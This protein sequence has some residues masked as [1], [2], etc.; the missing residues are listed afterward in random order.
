MARKQTA[1]KTKG[2]NRDLSVSAFNPEF[3]FENMNLR[4]STNEGNTTMSWVNEKGTQKIDDIVIDKKPWDSPENDVDYIEGIPIG[5]AIIDNKLVL[6]TTQRSTTKILPD[7]IYVLQYS[8]AEKTAIKG[9]MLYSGNLNF[10]ANY[11]IKTLVSYESPDIQKVYWVDG[12]NQPRVINIEASNSKLEKW[13][14]TVVGNE[15]PLDTFFDFVPAIKLDE[16]MTVTQDINS[17]GLFAPG[18]IQYCFS[19]INRNGQQTNIVEVSPLYYLTYADRGAS[20]ED[21]VGCSFK[22]DIKNP[23]KTFDYVRLYS[24][25]RTSLDAVPY[26]KLLDDIPVSGTTR[27]ELFSRK[28]VY[29]SNHELTLPKDRYGRILTVTVENGSY[30]VSIEAMAGT[31]SQ[32]YA[33]SSSFKIIGVD[34]DGQAVHTYDIMTLNELIDEVYN[35]SA[36]EDALFYNDYSAGI[37]ITQSVSTMLDDEVTKLQCDRWALQIGDNILYGRDVAQFFES[38]FIY[39]YKDQRWYISIENA[40]ETVT[41]N[42]QVGT[43]ITYVDNGTSGSSMDPQELLFVGGK[44]ITALTISDKDNTLF[45]GNLNEKNP[46]VTKIQDFFNSIRDV[47]D[48]EDHS[49]DDW[50][51]T[52]KSDSTK[53]LKMDVSRGFYHNTF[54]LNGKNHRQIT[55]FKGGETYRFG[56][57][58]Q[59]VTGEWTEPVWMNDAYNDKYPQCSLYK[60]T[61]NLVHAEVNFDFSKLLSELPDVD[62]SIY[63]RIRPVVVYPTIGDR[64]VLCQGVLNP[65][66]FNAMDRIDNSPYAQASWYFRPYMTGAGNTVPDI[67][68]E[69][70]SYVE[71]HETTP[72]VE[73]VDLSVDS[74][75]VSNNLLQDVYVMRVHADNSA[76]ESIRKKGSVTTRFHEEEYDPNRRG[77]EILADNWDEQPVTI[78]NTSTP[79]DYIF[80]S[81]SPFVL[82]YEEGGINEQIESE[83]Y[84]VYFTYPDGLYAM[85]M[86]IADRSF[87]LYNGMDH[88]SMYS[89]YYTN[90]TAN[91]SLDTYTFK[92]VIGNTYYSITFNSAGGAGN[93]GYAPYIGNSSGN[94]VEFN[95]YSSLFCEGSAANFDAMRKVEIQGSAQRYSSAFD[96]AEKTTRNNTQFFVDQ[97]IVTLNSP[98]LDFDTDVQN[99]PMNN[100]KLRIVGA[101]PITANVSAHAIKTSSAMLPGF[102]PSGSG[103]IFGLGELDINASQPNISR[104]AGNRLVADF[105]WNDVVVEHA[106]NDEKI[107]TLSDPKN[108]LVFPWHRNGS[109]NNDFRENSEASSVLETKKESNLLYSSNTEYLPISSQ[110]SYASVGA[111]VLL[112]ENDYVYNTRLPKQKSTT[113]DINYYGNIDKVLYNDAGYK[114]KTDDQTVNSDKIIKVMSPVHMKYKSGTHAVVALNA[115]EFGDLNDIPLLP[116]AHSEDGDCGNYPMD[117]GVTFWGDSVSFSQEGIDVDDLFTVVDSNDEVHHQ[118]HNFLWL[119]ELYKDVPW[120][121]GG[122]TREALRNNKWLVGGDSIDLYDDGGLPK[123]YFKLV[124]N[125][126]DTYYQR[127]DALKTYA[128]TPEDTNQIVEI[129]SFMCETR[130]NIDGRYDRNRGQIKSYLLNPTNFNLWNPVYSQKDNFF[131]SR[132]LDLGDSDNHSYPNQIAWSQTKVAGADTDAYT[133]ISLANTLDLDGDKGEVTS[134]QRFNDQLFAFQDSGISQILYNEKMQISTTEGVPVEI[135]NSGKVQGKRY[136]SDSI[137]CSDES[138]LVSTPSGI[139]FMDAINKGIYLFNGQVQN[140]SVTFGMNSWSKDNIPDSKTLWT[141]QSFA[142]FRAFYDRMNQDVLFVNKKTALAFS[143]K[144]GVFTSFYDYGN[145]PYFCNLDSTGLWINNYSNKDTETGIR[146]NYCELHKHQA[147]DYCKFFGTNKPYWMTLVGNP[148]PLND[149]L[150]TNVEFRSCVWGDGETDSATGRFIPYLPFDMLETWDEYQH[151]IANLSYKTGHLAFKHHTIDRSGSLKRKFRIWRCDIPRDNCPDLMDGKDFTSGTIRDHANP[152]DRMRNTWLY[153]KLMKH[154]APSDSSLNKTE[155]HDMVMTYFG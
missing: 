137:G 38:N 119:G 138:S 149:K 35:N 135:A 74:Y 24:I 121:F 96:T 56:F 76:I 53:Q 11:P 39:N 20:P 13:N 77:R 40:V 62:F 12:L 133:S 95:H 136:I 100:L 150:F 27:T 132:K 109:L 57:Q 98:D 115:E 147:G 61:V 139:Y 55:T 34:M 102:Y 73:P 123:K 69:A 23:D 128:Y 131:T 152:I 129:L 14:G 90:P 83:Q 104:R 42:E 125:D 94:P 97:S 142:G 10:N 70:A 108:F 17:G 48:S 91:S 37:H 144:L 25:Q 88:T 16:V 118:P 44:E 99:Y 2:M 92:F 111:E 6:F 26:V 106:S 49:L 143:E 30:D 140:L 46:L 153:L 75:F 112:S 19:Y 21:K 52:F 72:A 65:T 79:N 50:G 33:N 63:K 8:N 41:R 103:N 15:S 87:K 124:W 28:V 60:N 81:T 84:W 32:G 7:H 58:L 134:I 146:Y 126:G 22:I 78:I 107:D 155:I 148:E 85:N 4:L 3:A 1:W 89:M 93:K 43:Y 101:I 29:S 45:L 141:P 117:D 5:T 66:V 86:T 18:V 51:I 122:K 36:Y 68:E 105:L 59:K 54:T 9:K 64:S 145:I 127:Y 47:H 110:V 114:P 67:E 154:A 31:D 116:Y 151:G 130:T 82:P 80:V 71:Y 120:K 113:S